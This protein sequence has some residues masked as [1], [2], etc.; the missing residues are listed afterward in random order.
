MASVR[1][2]VWSGSATAWQYSNLTANEIIARGGPRA[3]SASGFPETTRSAGAGST[4]RVEFRLAVPT[5][6]HLENHAEILDPPDYEVLGD[7]FDSGDVS[8]SLSGPNLAII[9]PPTSGTEM[10]L[11]TN[12][13]T[14]ID[15]TRWLEA[16]DY[17]LDVWAVHQLRG[18]T[19]LFDVY[20]DVRLTAQKYI[21][22]LNLAAS[23]LDFCLCALPVGSAV[24]TRWPTLGSSP[25]QAVRQSNCRSHHPLCS[26]GL[27]NWGSISIARR[28]SNSA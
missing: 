26:R 11:P 23:R 5:L 22:F 1:D 15:E 16:G 8:F 7:I 20:Y 25:G 3:V 17:L 9:L 2:G 4:T 13:L 12:L 10:E 18:D 27:G 24:A 21:R 19:S 6:L 14:V 28:R